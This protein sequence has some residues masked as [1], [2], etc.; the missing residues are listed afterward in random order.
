MRDMWEQC[1]FWWFFLPQAAV[2]IFAESLWEGLGRKET[3]TWVMYGDGDG[4][5]SCGPVLD[6]RCCQR[7]CTILGWASFLPP[8][9][10]LARGEEWFLSHPGAEPDLFHQ[11]AEPIWTPETL[12]CC[13]TAHALRCQSLPTAVMWDICFKW[14]MV[15]KR[16]SLWSLMLQN[17]IVS[18]AMNMRQ[19]VSWGLLYCPGWIFSYSSSWPGISNDSTTLKCVVSVLG[20]GIFIHPHLHDSKELLEPY[21]S[22]L[23]YY[24]QTHTCCLCS[25]LFFILAASCSLLE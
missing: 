20:L 22:P 25:W 4:N 1:L 2:K 3:F 24:L 21:I 7:T 13:G 6:S 10:L 17:W 5:F 18:P 14:R 12:H 8:S 11:C 19:A 23:L 9:F 16:E 15:V